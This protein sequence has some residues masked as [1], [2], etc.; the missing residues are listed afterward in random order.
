VVVFDK[1]ERQHLVVVRA[2]RLLAEFVPVGAAPV[3]PGVGTNFS[4]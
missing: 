3:E 1:K 4:G 2:D